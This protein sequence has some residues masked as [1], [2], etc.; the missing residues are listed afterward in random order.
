MTE[1]A[2]KHM[3]PMVSP[4]DLHALIENGEVKIVHC[5]FFMPGKGDALDVFE[6]NRIPGAVHFDI[7]EVGDKSQLPL[8]HMIPTPEKFEDYV[9]ARGINNDDFIVVYGSDPDHPLDMGPARAWWMFRL[10][11]HD[12]V[13]VLDGGLPAWVEAGFEVE[14]GPSP[15]GAPGDFNAEFK[16]DLVATL[17]DVVSM[18]GDVSA[19][20]VD[21]RASERFQGNE[22]E[23]RPGLRSG[24]IPGSFNIPSARFYD[25]A[26]GTLRN[27]DILKAYFLEA[28]LDLKRPMIASCGSGVTACMVALAA[29]RLDLEE[30]VAVFDGSWTEYGSSEDLPVE[31]GPSRRV[32]L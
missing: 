23:P 5:T 3:D 26:T 17:D 21:V 28:G 9:R 20:I 29:A 13:A 1:K 12:K 30:N 18:L 2:E 32:G 10:Y 4:S 6:R 8:P 31:T 19:Q 22:V 7:D 14:M 25:P 24:H 11:G 16:E 15:Q 27:K